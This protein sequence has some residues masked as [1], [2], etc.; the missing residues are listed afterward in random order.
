MTYAQHGSASEHKRYYLP[1][2][3]KS[4]KKCHC[5]CNRRATHKGMANGVC[6][7]TGCELYI[8]RWVRDGATTSIVRT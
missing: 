2:A 7:T 6:L 1:V 3:T 4:R 5:G 8:R